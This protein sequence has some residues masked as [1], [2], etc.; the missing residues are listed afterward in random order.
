MHV[1]I[2]G[3]TGCY[4]RGMSIFENPFKKKSAPPE[5][6]EPPPIAVPER[7]RAND[8]RSE[9]LAADAFAQGPESLDQTAERK[10]AELAQEFNMGVEDLR[11]L[12][13]YQTGDGA[14]YGIR[15]T[16][17]GVALDLKQVREPAHGEGATRVVGTMGGREM[18]GSEIAKE[19]SRLTDAVNRRG[20]RKYFDEGQRDA[21]V[22]ARA[23][24]KD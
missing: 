9:P 24:G 15:G 4:T 8:N 14:L 5:R 6:I 18:Q 10:F 16:I 22:L 13:Q 2:K 12:E 3:S 19:F 1:G 23:Q 17:N 11:G 21:E 20:L 7:E